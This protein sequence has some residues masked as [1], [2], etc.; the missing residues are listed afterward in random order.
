LHVPPAGARRLLETLC[1]MSVALRAATLED[2]P[3]AAEVLLSSRRAFLPYAPSAH[4]DAE[5]HRWVREA[6]IPSGGVTVACA[7]TLV[8]GV[9]ATACTSGVSWVNQ[10]YIAPSH[11]GQGIGSRLLSHALLSLPLP[12]RLYT[13]QAN[14]RA[15][16]FYERHGFKAVAFSDG[17]A[18]EEHCPDVLYELAVPAQIGA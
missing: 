9:L 12:V 13:F 4:T 1:P 11:V 17:T 18:N 7:G 10:L 16:S 5:V 15:S 3:Q 2:A 14:T 8:V 6:L